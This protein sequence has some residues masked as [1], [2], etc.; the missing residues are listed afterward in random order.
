M[1]RHI[2]VNI[3]NSFKLDSNKQLLV[4]IYDGYNIDQEL[5]KK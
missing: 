5:S 1:D 4:N 2:N 3:I